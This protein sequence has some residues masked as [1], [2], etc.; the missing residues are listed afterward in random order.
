MNVGL[1]P[2]RV[3]KLSTLVRPK[4]LLLLGGVF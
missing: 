3:G 1:R 4:N 2:L